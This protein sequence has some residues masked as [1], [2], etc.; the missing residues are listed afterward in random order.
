MD[1]LKRVHVAVGVIRNAEALTCVS[2]RPQ[3][4]H[5]G[6]LWEFPG[7]KVEAGESVFAALARELNEELSLRIAA[8]EPLMQVSFQYPDKA[9]LLDVHLVTGFSGEAVGNEGQQVRW[10]DK[11]TLASLTFPQANAAIVERVLRL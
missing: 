11:K 8:S 5:M 4:V 6:G 2:L 9:V 10:V 7:G 3:H 1:D